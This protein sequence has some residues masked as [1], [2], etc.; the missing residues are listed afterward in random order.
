MS[1]EYLC[2][3]VDDSPSTES[4]TVKCPSCRGS[5]RIP[6]EYESQLVAII[7]VRDKRLKPRRTWLWIVLTLAICII[8]ASL[9]GFFLAPRS[10][11]LSLRSNHLNGTKIYDNN[12]SDFTQSDVK[13]ISILSYKIT[14]TNFYPIYISKLQMTISTLGDFDSPV[15]AGRIIDNSKFEIAL[16]SE[17][18]HNINATM[19]LRSV[20]GQV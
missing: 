2:D 11:K 1:T 5:G 15:Q 14:N 18:N 17:A 10:V 6:K 12:A 4:V 16:K 7:P 19:E 13:V 3:S 20:M 9:L 8:L